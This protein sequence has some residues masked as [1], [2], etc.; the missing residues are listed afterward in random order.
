MIII[1]WFGDGQT[2][3]Y[4]LQKYYVYRLSQSSVLKRIYEKVDIALPVNNNYLGAFQVQEIPSWRRT[5][6]STQPI[7]HGCK[8][9]KSYANQREEIISL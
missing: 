9:G 1:E 6:V 5:Y 7:Q 4:V 3:S 8:T 2:L